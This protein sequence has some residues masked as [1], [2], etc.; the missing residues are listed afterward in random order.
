MVFS[1][2]EGRPAPLLVGTI[3]LGLLLLLHAGGPRWLSNGVMLAAVLSVPS[4]I[5]YISRR[6]QHSDRSREST[7]PV[8]PDLLDR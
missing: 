3:G 8:Q 6:R 1:Y 7:R 5:R 2:T 4:I